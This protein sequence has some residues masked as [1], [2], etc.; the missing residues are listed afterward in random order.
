M[1]VRV[2]KN[3]NLGNVPITGKKESRATVYAVMRSEEHSDEL[4]T[5]YFSLDD[6]VE[7]CTGKDNYYVIDSN[8]F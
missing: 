2:E 4:V 5:C 1:G 3:C 7:Y 8:V 6:A